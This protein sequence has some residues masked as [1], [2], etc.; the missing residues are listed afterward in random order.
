LN[1]SYAVE[2]HVGFR[3]A[4]RLASLASCLLVSSLC[5]TSDAGRSIPPP[6]RQDN[7]TAEQR[8]QKAREAIQAERY[9]DARKE[10]KVALLL[11]KQSPA[12]NLCLAFVYKQQGKSKDAIK[13]VQTAIK[14]QPIYPDAHYLFAQLLSESH[15]LKRARQEID[16]AISQSP[17]IRD[18]HVLSGDLYLIQSGYEPALECYEKALALSDPNDDSADM[19]RQRIAALTNNVEFKSHRNDPSYVIPRQ[20][21]FPRPVYPEQARHRGTQGKV[22]MGIVVDENGKVASVLILSSL[23]YGMDAEALKATQTI[24]FS[25]ATRE[26]KP[27]PYWYNVIIEFNIEFNVR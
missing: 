12:A 1:W 13:S 17:S 11:D 14:L 8:V 23:G 2:S 22:N 4:S 9:D 16:L 21:N 15:D 6:V 19:L 20:I 26:G 25:P 5:A 3:K 24:R 27:V 18:A 7:L 10:L